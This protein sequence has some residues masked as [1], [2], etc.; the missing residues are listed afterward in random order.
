MKKAVKVIFHIDINA[1]YAQVAIIKDPYLVNEVFVVGGRSSSPRGVITTASY[2]ARKY[3]IKSG[4]S[5]AAAQDIFPKL[6]IVPADFTLIS[7]ISKQFFEILK[8][9]S[10]RVLKASI[11]EA[12]VDVTVLSETKH[13]LEIAKEIQTRLKNELNLPVSIGIAPTLFLAKMG[14]DLKKPLGI[15]V[16]RKKEIAEKILPLPIKELHGVGI[17]TYPLLEKRGIKTIGDF[18]LK[19]NLNKVLEVMKYEYYQ[20]LKDHI[21]GNSSNIVDP[22]KYE[23]PKSISNET[24][25]NYNIDNYEVLSQDINLIFN[26]SYERL[27]KEKALAKTVSIKIKDANFNTITRSKT[28]NDFSKDYETFKII[29]DSLFYEN[30]DNKPIRLIGVGFSNII[31]ESMYEDEYN[32]FTYQKHLK[33]KKWYNRK[34]KERLRW[35]KC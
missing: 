7:E 29:V 35:K 5:F 25:F 3:G 12:Y 10:N 18:V 24:T 31:L 15:T 28:I 17:K 11:D 23:I 30:F 8:T 21:Y 26:E 1:F 33:N 6:L 20:T 9:Y 4:M 2:K 13:P 34:R 27:I 16:I 32:L 14:S 22:H 19:E